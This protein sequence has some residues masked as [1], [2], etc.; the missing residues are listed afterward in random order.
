MSCAEGQTPQREGTDGAGTGRPADVKQGPVPEPSSREHAD[1]RVCGGGK[2]AGSSE[3]C[4]SKVS[5]KSLGGE[6]QRGEDRGRRWWEM[7]LLVT[8]RK[9]LAEGQWLSG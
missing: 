6:A 9:C 7:I 5:A 8:E 2:T 3:C 1:E 4:A